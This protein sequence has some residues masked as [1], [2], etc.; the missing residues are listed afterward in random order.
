ML[1]IF[2]ASVIILTIAIVAFLVKMFFVKDS[3]FIKQCLCKKNE[4]NTD[5][6]CLNSCEFADD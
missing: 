3:T 6:N 5:K 1:K 2:L 4:N